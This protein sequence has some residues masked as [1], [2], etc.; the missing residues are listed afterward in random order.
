VDL[1]E[2]VMRHWSGGAARCGGVQWRWRALG[3]RQRHDRVLH[4]GG[5]EREDG[6]APSTMKQD[7]KGMRKAK[8]TGGGEDDGALA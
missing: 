4:R 7:R 5:R 1:P 8:L 2:T 6:E 3:G